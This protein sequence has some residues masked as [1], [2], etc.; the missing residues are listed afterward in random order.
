MNNVYQDDADLSAKIPNTNPVSTGLRLSY[1][2]DEHNSSVTSASGS[3]TT[4]PVISSLDDSVRTEIDRQKEEF[5]HYI[6]LQEEQISK[7]LR[8]MQERHMASFLC[9]I[10]NS[11]DRKLREKELDI[12]NM[13][14]K[15]RELVERIKQAALEAQSWQYRVRCSESV[16]NVL[17]NNLKQAI[18]EG[19][20]QGKEGCGD[21]EVD[22]TAS[23]FDHNIIPS[24]PGK[25][26]LAKGLKEQMICWSCKC[27]GVSI[28]LFPC[29]HLC[30]CKNC[31]GFVEVCP[32]CQSMKTASVQVY[33]S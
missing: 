29:R 11:V 14:R 21:S 10:E 15:N 8:E 2:D 23:S 31:E 33:M 12:G 32:I 6:R 16:V 9:A 4:L 17:K 26:F 24:I 13:N 5:D 27:M 25:S 30:L 7:G 28:L 1:D 3:M 20:Y 22:D 19:A 18:A